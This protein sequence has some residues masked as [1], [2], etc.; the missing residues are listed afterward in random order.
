MIKVTLAV[1]SS[2]PPAGCAPLPPC[3]LSFYLK[4]V[5]LPSLLSSSS[6][7]RACIG[8]LSPWSQR[9]VHQQESK[10]DSLERFSTRYQCYQCYATYECHVI[11]SNF[12]TFKF[13]L[14]NFQTVNL[15]TSYQCILLQS[16]AYNP[17][18][19]GSLHLYSAALDLREKKV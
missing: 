15:K 18:P 9:L 13:Q 14:S 5:A 19:Q 17:D 7:T 8:R 6:A 16:M 11:F 3:I 4:Q 12:H 1:F 2:L 10:Q